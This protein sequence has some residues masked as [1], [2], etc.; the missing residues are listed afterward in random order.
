[1]S[2]DSKNCFYNYPAAGVFPSRLKAER[3]TMKAAIAFSAG[4][5]MPKG[6]VMANADLNN[7]SK[8][9]SRDVISVMKAVLAASAN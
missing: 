5:E 8:L 9:N 7:D 1:M 6:F 2:S 4:T 3:I